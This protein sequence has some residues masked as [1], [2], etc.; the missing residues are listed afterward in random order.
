LKFYLIGVCAGLAAEA[1]RAWA[2][3]LRGDDDDAF[4]AASEWMM[5]TSSAIRRCSGGASCSASTATNATA[6]C[7]SACEPASSLRVSGSSSSSPSTRCGVV[8]PTGGYI[9]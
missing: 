6:R 2:A 4:T 9:G 1:G 3:A 8:V 7:R 5:S